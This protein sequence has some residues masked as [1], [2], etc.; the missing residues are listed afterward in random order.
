MRTFEFRGK[1]LPLG[2]CAYVMGILNVTP[3]SFSDGGR[4]FEPSA[5]VEHA[6]AMLRDGADII[7]IGAVSTRPDGETADAEEEWKRLK[8]VLPAIRKLTDAPLSVDTFRPDVAEK[9]LE[10]GADIIND[11]SGVYRDEM[12]EVIKKYDAGWILMHG[13]IFV[14]ATAAEREYPA[15]I[16]NDVQWFYDEVA[17]KTAAGGIDVSRICVDP[18]FGFGKNVEQNAELLRNFDLLETNGMAHLCA[19][20]R[21]RFIGALSEDVGT[22]RTGGTLAADMIALTKGAD[23]I[24]V[25]ETAMHGKAVTFYNSLFK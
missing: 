18:G 23:I 19:L 15:G 3:D 22:E 7:D 13:G 16:V 12:A 11:V 5:A 24:R 6:A 20:S 21:K 4:Y 9:C 10:A 1:C 8:D 2:K 14:S 17:V 25:H